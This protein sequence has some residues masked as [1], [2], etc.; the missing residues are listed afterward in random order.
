M[1]LKH[2]K[3]SVASFLAVLSRLRCNWVHSMRVIIVFVF[4]GRASLG[5]VSLFVI[6][7]LF[8]LVMDCW[9]LELGLGLVHLG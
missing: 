3:A 4:R 6:L 9:R 2:G 1:P 8:F 7:L 5:I